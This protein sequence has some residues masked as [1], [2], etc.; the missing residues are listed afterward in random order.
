MESISSIFIGLLFLMGAVIGIAIYLIPTIIAVKADHPSKAAIIVL[1]VLGGWTFIVW[2]LSLVW[3]LSK[4]TAYQAGGH[5]Y[6][7]AAPGPV[8]PR[9]QE[10]TAADYNQGPVQNLQES[11]PLLLG[12]KGR[13]ADQTIDLSYGPVAIGRDPSVSHLVYPDDNNRISRKHCVV[14]YDRK[15]QKFILED[16]SKNGTFV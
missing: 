10:Q 13:F 8:M 3:A 2:V 5:H 11:K 12:I 16:S 14:G 9:K 1:N 4:P 6:Q 15:Q 7:Q